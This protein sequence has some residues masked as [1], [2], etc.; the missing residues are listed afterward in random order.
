MSEDE[1]DALSELEKAKVDQQRLEVK[2]LRL[3]RFTTF[4][5]I[6]TNV[7]RAP[8]GALVYISDVRPDLFFFSCD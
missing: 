6:C 2:K 7:K 1:Y 5:G 4:T 3:Q 8:K